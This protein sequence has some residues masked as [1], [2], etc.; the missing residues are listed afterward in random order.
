MNINK[1][2]LLAEEWDEK[3]HPNDFKEYEENGLLAEEWKDGTMPR[4]KVTP[5]DLWF[6]KCIREAA[7][8]KCQ[9]CGKQ[10]EEG[11]QG[12][13]CSHYFGRR[14][15]ALR[16]CPDN[17]FAHC[18]GCHQ[19]LGAN[20]DDFRRWVAERIGEGMIDVLREKREDIGLAKSIKK[21]LKDVAK[22]Y[23]AEYE[24]L[25]SKRL[26]GEMGELEVF[27]Y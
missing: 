7:A 25:K 27:E 23:K 13:H 22:H 17:A 2:G 12:L 11:T 10:Y 4:L 14:A 18:F 21:N 3:I 19:R 6:S 9:C 24:R 16:Y 26:E 5:A 1:N 20:P 15:N 8:W